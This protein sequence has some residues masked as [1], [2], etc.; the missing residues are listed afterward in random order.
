MND[1]E[2]WWSVIGTAEVIEEKPVAV[3]IRKK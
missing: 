2:H 3:P 1:Y